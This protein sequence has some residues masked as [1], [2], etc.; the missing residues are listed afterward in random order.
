M[1]RIATNSFAL[2]IVYFGLLSILGS[3][4]ATEQE[5]SPNPFT[6]A[7]AGDM[8]HFSG[9]GIFNNA[10]FFR[11]AMKA[12]K[13]VG[14]SAFMV[15]PGDLDPVD[16]VKWTIEQVMGPEYIWYPVV[17]NHELPGEGYESYYGRNMDLLRNYNYDK[18]GAG[19]PPDIVNKGPSGCPQTTYSFDYENTHFVVLNV[20]CDTGGDTVTTG[21]VPDHLYHWLVDD[22]HATSKKFIFVFGHEPAFPRPDADNGRLRHSTDSLNQYPSKRTRFW[23]LLRDAGV[24]AYICGHT[25]N[26]SVYYYDGVWQVDTGHARGAGDTGA[27]STFL[28]IHVDKDRVTYNAYRDVHDR[29]YDYDDI[30]H[31]GTLSP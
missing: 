6:F 10:N 14:G 19:K 30:I 21:T 1:K 26:H 9:D 22:L 5:D 29:D 18:N 3:G 24:V 4:G 15:V 17:G 25:H 7:V 23:N 20:Y 12:I 28:M 13:V 8:T 31:K 16:N 27:A 2:L 11:G